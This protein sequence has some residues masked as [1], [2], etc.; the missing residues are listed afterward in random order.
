MRLIK[1]AHRLRGTKIIYLYDVTMRTKINKVK[2]YFAFIFRA[3]IVYRIP[4]YRVYH[5]NNDV[6]YVHD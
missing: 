5:V 1:Y 2:E 6:I 3:Y 4:S